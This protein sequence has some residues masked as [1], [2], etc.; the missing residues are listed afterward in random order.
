M[1]SG[2]IS[3]THVEDVSR[4]EIFVAENESASGRYICC[5]INTS[6]PELAEFLS[7]RYPQYNVPTNFTDV[8]KK[9][10]LSLSSTKL[11]REGFK[12][13]KKDLGTIY[14]DSIEYVK[15]AGLLPN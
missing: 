3:F 14:E 15:T 1:L 8:S 6:L 4:A 10:R 12:F 7:K 13:E 11:I 2:S 5:A 9:A